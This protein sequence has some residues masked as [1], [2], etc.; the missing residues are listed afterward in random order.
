MEDIIKEIVSIITDYGFRPDDI[1]INTK[2]EI[3]SDKYLLEVRLRKYEEG[4]P[5]EGF[6]T[7]TVPIEIIEEVKKAGSGNVEIRQRH[8]VIDNDDLIRLVRKAGANAYVIDNKYEVI[9]TNL[10]SAL[11]RLAAFV[12]YP[13]TTSTGVSIFTADQFVSYFL[14]NKDIESRASSLVIEV[15][16]FDV[17]AASLAE[18]NIAEIDKSVEE[19]RSLITEPETEEFKERVASVLDKDLKPIMELIKLQKP[20][21]FSEDLHEATLLSDLNTKVSTIVRDTIKSWG[22]ED[23]QVETN[24][25]KINLAKGIATGTISCYNNKG[26]ISVVASVKLNPETYTVEGIDSPLLD[27]V[28]SR[29]GVSSFRLGSFKGEAVSSD[30]FVQ[31]LAEMYPD[32]AELKELLNNK[33]KP[34]RIIDSSNPDSLV[35]Y[36]EVYRDPVTNRLYLRRSENQLKIE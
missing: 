19:V 24:L 12:R 1:A 11:R 22:I 28:K 9:A 13:Y 26:Y 7:E 5:T 35:T 18:E 31:N 4:Y 8:P 21:L 34:V 25:E 2:A 10:K 14:R 36:W 15:P 20:D 33:W 27:L 17:V 30:V 32:N 16:D 3:G 23:I 29:Y 6:I